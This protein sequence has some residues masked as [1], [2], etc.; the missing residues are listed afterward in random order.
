LA[1]VA[2]ALGGGLAGVEVHVGVLA[3]TGVGDGGGE[4][5]ERE[6]CCGDHGGGGVH[7]E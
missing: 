5:G 4:G 6:G 1:V 3:V 7:L 2:L